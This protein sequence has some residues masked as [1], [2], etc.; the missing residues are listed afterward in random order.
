MIDLSKYVF[1]VLRKDEVFILY[2]G[3]SKD[4]A[5]QAAFASRLRPLR[6]VLG[7]EAVEAAE[8]RGRDVELRRDFD[9]TSTSSVESL[10]RVAQSSRSAESGYDAP[11]V[12]DQGRQAG[13]ATKSRGRGT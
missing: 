8:N 2:R 13:A 7:S 1:E 11:L 6:R 10:S 4:D 3:Q 12:S 9:E 5:S